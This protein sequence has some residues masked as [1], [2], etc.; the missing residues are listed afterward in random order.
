M[1]SCKP[2][3]TIFN[4]SG[5]RGQDR[6]SLSSP[7]PRPPPAR[8]GDYGTAMAAPFSS[9]SGSYLREPIIGSPAPYRLAIIGRH[10]CPGT[11][12]K[13]GMPSTIWRN[14]DRNRALL[15]RS[16]RLDRGPG[17]L[18]VVAK[19]PPLG[20]DCGGRILISVD[21]VAFPSPWESPLW[22][23]PSAAASDVSSRGTSK[24]ASSRSVT[25]SYLRDG[26]EYRALL[27]PQIGADAGRL[28]NSDQLNAC[29]RCESP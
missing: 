17:I 24:I 28:A 9:N 29:R 25:L 15:L 13:S 23:M 2:L 7:W 10:V 6:W 26:R 3:H 22:K 4:R 20:P 12:A 18:A 14:F 1:T 11:G 21:R 16:Y 19:A 8:S 5:R 27:E